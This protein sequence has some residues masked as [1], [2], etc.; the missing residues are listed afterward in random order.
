MEHKNAVLD[1]LMITSLSCKVFS[2]EESAV[3]GKTRV[4]LHF[5]GSYEHPDADFT[6]KW[7][8]ITNDSRQNDKEKRT[9]YCL[10][11]RVE[12]GSG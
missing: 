3:K 11:V 1:L 8:R 6:I 5:S 10:R 9:E 4:L 2:Q 12:N 7:E